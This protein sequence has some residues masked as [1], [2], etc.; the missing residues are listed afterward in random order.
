MSAAPGVPSTSAKTD[1]AV[2]LVPLVFASHPWNR[3]SPVLENCYDSG[4]TFL[5]APRNAG[6]IIRGRIK[7]EHED[8]ASP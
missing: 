1:A 7:I 3:I 8:A 5:H 6:N 2:L 4:I